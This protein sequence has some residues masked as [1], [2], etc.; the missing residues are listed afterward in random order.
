[1]KKILLGFAVLPLLALLA[2]SCANES[3]ESKDDLGRVLTFKAAAGKQTLSRAAEADITTLQ[4]NGPLEVY[5]YKDG[6]GSLY[7]KFFLS[8]NIGSYQWEYSPVKFHPIDFGLE[9]YS[10]YPAE[11][12]TIDGGV[13]PPQFE[14]VA[15]WDEDLMVASAHTTHDSDSDATA[16]LVYRHVLSQVNFAIQGKDHLIIEIDD[17]EVVGVKNKGTYHFNTNEWGNLV[18]DGNPVYMYDTSVRQNHTN[19]S[20]GDN[21][22]V[23]YLGNEGNNGNNGFGNAL[24]LM[25]QSFS[26]GGGAGFTFHY[27]LSNAHGDDMIYEGTAEVYFDLLGTEWQQGRRYLYIIAFNPILLQFDVNVVEDWIDADEYPY[28]ILMD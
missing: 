17:I 2:T 22:N 7:E 11:N 25:P 4:Q 28:H 3:V 21:D 27:V 1:M 18:K 15:E 10:V 14:Y 16:N 9:H 19:G 8:Y 6:F 24:M 26:P 20:V 12:A 13:Y 5:T 23:Y